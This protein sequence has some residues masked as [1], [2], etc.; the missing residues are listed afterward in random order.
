[1]TKNQN[2]WDDFFHP[3]EFKKITPGGFFPSFLTGP[4]ILVIFFPS[5]DIRVFFNYFFLLWREGRH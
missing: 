3:T 5:P 2:M 1:M 4:P